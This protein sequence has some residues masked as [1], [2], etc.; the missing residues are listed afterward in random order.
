MLMGGA[1]MS[2]ME[3]FP[4]ASCHH[5]FADDAVLPCFRSTLLDGYTLYVYRDFSAVKLKT[6]ELTELIRLSGGTAMSY[7]QLQSLDRIEEK[8]RQNCF[9]I[10]PMKGMM[11]SIA[12]ALQEGHKIRIVTHNWLLDSVSANELQ[13]VYKESY[14]T[15]EQVR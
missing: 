9:L 6:T 4:R 11:G 7:A 15:V 2:R 5:M 13:D 14:C 8:D 10:C 3:R 1:R 12:R